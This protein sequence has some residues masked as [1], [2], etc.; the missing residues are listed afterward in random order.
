[1]AYIGRTAQQSTKMPNR[2]PPISPRKH[3]KIGINRMYAEE[4]QIYR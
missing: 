3:V 2:K 4:A 1:M